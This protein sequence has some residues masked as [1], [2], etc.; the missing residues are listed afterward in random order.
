L[1]AGLGNQAPRLVACFVDLIE[2]RIQMSMVRIQ[3]LAAAGHP[4]FSELEAGPHLGD[5][6]RGLR[7]VEHIRTALEQSLGVR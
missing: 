7:H 5:M 6:Q 3:N 2:Q 1:S 4:Q